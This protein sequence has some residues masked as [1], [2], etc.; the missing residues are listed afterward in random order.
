MITP[1]PTVSN[2]IKALKAS[3]DLGA[4]IVHH[5]TKPSNPP[6][7]KNIAK[8]WPHK[9]DHGLTALAIDR[10]YAHQAEALDAIRNGNDVIVST[11]TASGKS[12]IYNL[13]VFEKIIAKPDSKALYLFPLKALALL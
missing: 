8:P 11:P 2:Y 3:P 12:L 7:Y 6:G 5:E 1:E 13:P 9:L 4:Q 10:L